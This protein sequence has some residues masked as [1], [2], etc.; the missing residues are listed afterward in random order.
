MYKNILFLSLIFSSITLAKVHVT[1]ES[2]LDENGNEQKANASLIVNEG[3]VTE[4]P[5]GDMTCKMVISSKDNAT[6]IG[7]F[8]MRRN[9]E[10]LSKPFLV[11]NNEQ[12]GTIEL[13]DVTPTSQSRFYF[14]FT[15]QYVAD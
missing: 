8:E 10:L 13:R 3:E 12:R 15:A 9:G 11:V 2:I 1:L 5:L 14:S 6:I 7:D 4:F